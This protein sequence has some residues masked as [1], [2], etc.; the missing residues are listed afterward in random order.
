MILKV[1]KNFKMEFVTD[2]IDALDGFE[3]CSI[4]MILKVKKNSKMEFVAD[5]IGAVGEYEYCNTN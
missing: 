3:Y 2:S 4:N 1:K 5:S